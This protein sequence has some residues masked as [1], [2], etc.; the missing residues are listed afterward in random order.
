ME[1]GLHW[2][3][4]Q[5]LCAH[6]GRCAPLGTGLVDKAPPWWHTLSGSTWWPQGKTGLVL[7]LLQLVFRDRG[8]PVHGETKV[9]S[10]FRSLRGRPEEGTWRQMAGAA[11]CHEQEA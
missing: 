5:K 3:D 7:S 2:G 11:R 6:S 1:E 8:R 10:G 4:G 9:G